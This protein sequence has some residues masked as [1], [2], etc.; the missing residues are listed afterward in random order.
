MSLDLDCMPDVDGESESLR[1]DLMLF[2]TIHKRNSFKRNNSDMSE[3]REGF[4]TP[5]PEKV[6]D[7]GGGNPFSAN[8]LAS[9]FP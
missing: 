4:K 3:L 5:V 8:F 7:G 1:S 6:R 2:P 9:R